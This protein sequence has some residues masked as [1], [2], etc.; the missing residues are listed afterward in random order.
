VRSIAAL[1]LLAAGCAYYRT[2]EE[3]VDAFYRQARAFIAQRR[4]PEQALALLDRAIALAPHRSEIV[5]TRA[6]LHRETGHLEAARDDY[7]TAARLNGGGPADLLVR[8]GAAEGEL[9]F[10]DRAETALGEAIRQDPTHAEAYL[11]RARFRR[12]AGRPADADRDLADARS[13]GAAWVEP[14]HNEGVRLLRATRPLEAERWFRYATELDPLRSESWIGLG[15]ALLESRRPFLAEAAFA[16]AAALRKTD[17]ETHYHRGIA[18]LAAGRQEEA[19]QAYTRAV[20]LDPAKP[21]YFTG[22]GMI[23]QQEYRDP[24]RAAA[25]YDRALALDPEY[26]PALFNRAILLH[27]LGRQPEAEADLRRSLSRRGSV[28]GARLLASI[29][30]EQGKYDVAMNVCL[31]AIQLCKD[32]AVREGLDDELRRALARKEIPR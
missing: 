21:A 26:P 7:A 14:F 3:E 6:G 18:L 22:R 10:L 27:E 20:E 25:E 11:Q 4:D 19:L 29:L 28:D 13:R 9:G 12:L 8:L 1:L 24:A 32:P 2:E 16:E 17:P 15:R 23:Y 5:E 31:E 30:N